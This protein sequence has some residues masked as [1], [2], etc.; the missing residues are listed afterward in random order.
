MTLVSLPNKPYLIILITLTLLSL[1]T[2]SVGVNVV[3]GCLCAAGT[4]GSVSP[5]V[6]A[7]YYTSDCS[8][9]IYIGLE[10]RISGLIG[11]RVNDIYYIFS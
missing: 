9:H 10:I 1:W 2:D 3:S 5:I 4:E 6:N 8:G 11:E 7:P